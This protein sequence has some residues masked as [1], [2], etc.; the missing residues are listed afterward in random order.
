MMVKWIL[1]Q[2]N[3][4]GFKKGEPGMNRET[5]ASGDDH[6]RNVSGR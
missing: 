4:L 1:S 3:G 5:Y 2:E 6:G